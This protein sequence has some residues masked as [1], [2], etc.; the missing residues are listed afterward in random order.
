MKFDY[1]ILFWVKNI[2][3]VLLFVQIFLCY[4]YYVLFIGFNLVKCYNCYILVYSNWYVGVEEF[5]QNQLIICK[6]ILL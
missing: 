3:I 5:N 2:F 6:Y 1:G 4:F